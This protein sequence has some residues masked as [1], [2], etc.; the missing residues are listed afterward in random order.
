MLARKRRLQP[1]STGSP[2]GT[3]ATVNR[4][5]TVCTSCGS[6][7]D[8]ATVSTTRCSGVSASCCSAGATNENSPRTSTGR[9]STSRTIRKG[10]EPMKRKASVSHDEAIVR[11]LRKDPEFSAEYLKSAL[12]DADK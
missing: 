5:A 8:P 1:E 2:P 4:C 11:R 6:I 10:L 7:G 9:W 12:E 3:L